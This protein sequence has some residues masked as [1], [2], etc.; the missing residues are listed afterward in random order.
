MTATVVAAVA[1]G[2]SFT[3]VIVFVGT[4]ELRGRARA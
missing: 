4:Q 3:G 1:S 2:G